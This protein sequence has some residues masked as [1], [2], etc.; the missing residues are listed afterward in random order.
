M[1]SVA[2]PE[3]RV[4]L[5]GSGRASGLEHQ[6]HGLMGFFLEKPESCL[7]KAASTKRASDLSRSGLGLKGQA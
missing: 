6:R 4:G 2:D 5:W 1:V 7:A 3:E